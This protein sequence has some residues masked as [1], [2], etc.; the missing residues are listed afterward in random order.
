PFPRRGS[1]EKAASTGYAGAAPRDLHHSAGRPPLNDA[2]AGFMAS[3]DAII[4]IT[5]YTGILSDLAV[6]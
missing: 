1:E 3:D 6:I 5:G 2:L 4:E